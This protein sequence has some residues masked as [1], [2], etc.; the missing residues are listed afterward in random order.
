[1]RKKQGTMALYAAVFSLALCS[2]QSGAGNERLAQERL[3]QENREQGSWEKETAAQDSG[4]VSDAEERGK[5]QE[6]VARNPL[7]QGEERDQGDGGFHIKAVQNLETGNE[8][9]SAAFLKAGDIRYQVSFDLTREGMES[10]RIQCAFSMRNADHSSYY[11][12]I[13][14]VEISTEKGRRSYEIEPVFPDGSSYMQAES[15]EIRFCLDGP[16]GPYISVKGLH[17]LDGDYY[18]SSVFQGSGLMFRYLTKADLC[19][20]PTEDLWLLRNEIY[21]LHGRIFQNEVLRQYFETYSWYRGTTEPGAFSEDILSDVEKKNVALIKEMEDDPNRAM[22]DGSNHYGIED[23]PFAPYLSYL[24]KYDET[25]LSADLTQAKDMGGYYVVQGS[26]SVP[27]SI[28][29]EQLEGVKAGKEVE[30]VLDELTGEA[31]ILTLDPGGNAADPVYGY[32]LREYAEDQGCETGLWADYKSGTYQLWQ[33]SGD[34]VMKTVYRGDIYLL[35]GTVTGGDVS[36]EGASENQ[37]LIFASKGAGERSGGETDVFG[38]HLYY[39]SRG[40]FTAVYYLGD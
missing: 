18:P 37:R 20:Y 16:A 14:S 13:A 10:D 8:L 34:T 32:I 31:G 30:V 2:C 1:M 4:D 39:N 40:H 9:L 28:T 33:T 25:G 21:A 17:E 19:M 23:L 38:N 3:E 29:P 7:K 27:A 22:L 12:S 24:G 35:K 26:I 11:D 6:E 36:L 15:G 5:S